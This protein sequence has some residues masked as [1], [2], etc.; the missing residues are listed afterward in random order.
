MVQEVG[1]GDWSQPVPTVVGLSR[2]LE[3]DERRCRGVAMFCAVAVFCNS[4]CH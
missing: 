3:N 2:D 1:A 4:L